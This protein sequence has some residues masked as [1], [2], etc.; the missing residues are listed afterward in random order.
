MLY[1]T[2]TNKYTVCDKSNWTLATKHAV[3]EHITIYLKA[4]YSCINWLLIVRMCAILLESVKHVNWLA[5]M[6]VTNTS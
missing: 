2:L 1:R 6:Q 5:I 4:L 3:S